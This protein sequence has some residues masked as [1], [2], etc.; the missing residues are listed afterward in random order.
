MRV[1]NIVKD[2]IRSEIEKKYPMDNLP[3]YEDAISRI[4]KFEEEINSKLDAIVDEA[5]STFLA[6]NPDIPVYAANVLRPSF[7]SKYTRRHVG[8]RDDARIYYKSEWELEN[9]NNDHLS[10]IYKKR[11]DAFNKIVVALE[12][13]GTK[14][15][16]ERM[17]EDL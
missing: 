5:K 13:G 12:L 2:Y 4:S 9:N 14:A 16:L 1:S 17:L 15:D 7:R 3:E 6:S 8:Y 11:E 10:D